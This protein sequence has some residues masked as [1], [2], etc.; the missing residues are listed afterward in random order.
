MKKSA[1]TAVLMAIASVV[2]YCG[3]T[4]IK[5][6]DQPFSKEE[7][8][9]IF[10]DNYH[11]CED[12]Y[13][14]FA[15]MVRGNNGA[16][17]EQYPYPYSS[18]IGDTIKLCGYVKHSY[19]NTIHYKDNCWY[20]TLIDDSVTAMDPDDYSG[21]GFYVQ[22]DDKML[23]ANVNFSQKCYLTGY[24]TFY[25]LFRYLG[26]PAHPDDCYCRMPYFRVIE[27]RN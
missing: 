2:L 9:F 1:F 20:C 3:C 27:I 26:G 24:M 4:H 6:C 13:K 11:S 10:D 25:S 12:V 14:N 22:G 7:I 16:Y 15:Y 19:G 8:P 5:K 17:L 18:H 21:G 23:L